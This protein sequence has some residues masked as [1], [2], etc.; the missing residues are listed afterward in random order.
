[1]K[2][3]ARVSHRRGAAGFTLVEL[4]VA[5]VGGMFV[6]IAVFSLAKHASGFSLKES[7][8]ADA[9]MQSVV[10]FERLKAEI[11]RAGFL[12]TPNILN[13]QSGIC[14][15]PLA[16]G[17]PAGL[18]DLSSVIIDNVPVAQ[19]SSEITLNG[20]APK[21]ITIAGSLASSDQFPALN[22]Q[23]GNPVVVFLD[24]NSQGMVNIGYPPANDPAT[25][26]RVF[27][28]GRALRIVD[29]QGR[30][31]FASITG[32]TGGPNPSITLGPNPAPLFRSGSAL[33]C[34][35]TGLGNDLVNVVNIVR[36][37]IQNL[38]NAALFP[39]FRHMFRGGPTYE[40][41]R[42]ELTRQELDVNGASI[43]GTLELIAEYAVD[44]GFSLLV[45]P[46]SLSPLV[47][48]SSTG[49]IAGYAGP[50]A[51]RTAG[52]G[53]QQIRAIHAWLSVRSQ[54]AD[55]STGLSLTT[56]AP[57]PNRLRISVN[58][59]NASLPPFARLRTVQATVPL[60]NQA[61][62]TW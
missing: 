43:P 27:G 61:K 32:V 20:I 54:E 36:Y 53:P 30:A 4:M 15:A 55:R 25:L 7:R 31:Q 42:R 45:A 56:T 58:P 57:G 51:A 40:A 35:I 13:A 62:I 21:R 60:N 52:Q 6:S 11:S 17:F 16:V 2:R 34:G 46:N 5:M 49:D 38:N 12:S 1:M 33:N 8:L 24:P 22:I 14:G 26:G 29:D 50:P 9:T 59:T 47:R 10:G 23:Q 39:G 3:R 41:T 28:T 37:D 18:R 48:A 44:L 19:L